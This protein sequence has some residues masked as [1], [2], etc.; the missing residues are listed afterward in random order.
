MR[1]G[2]R[3]LI[4]LGILAL[5]IGAA[6]GQTGGERPPDVRA[7]ILSNLKKSD[8]A[9]DQDARLNGPYPREQLIVPAGRAVDGVEVADGARQT[10][11]NLYGWAWQTCMRANVGGV[12]YTYAVFIASN[13]VI[14]VRGALLP[15]RCDE[16]KYAALPFSRAQVAPPKAGKSAEGAAPKKPKN[17]AK[18]LQ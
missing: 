13:R 1:A 8:S 7:V 14:D 10:L 18:K 12:R 4:C 17:R 2:P 3:G 11:T 9:S 15:D 16:A 6:R 5:T